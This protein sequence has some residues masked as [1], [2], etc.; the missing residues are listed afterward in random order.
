MFSYVESRDP[1][2][3][4][5]EI[6]GGREAAL[7]DVRDTAEFAA[8]HAKGAVSMPLAKLDSA[9]IRARLGEGVGTTQALYVLSATGVR[10]ERAV[11][12]LRNTGLKNTVLVNGGFEAW[13]N[14]QLPTARNDRRPSLEQQ[15]HIMVGILLVVVLTKAWLLHPAFYALLG[16][17][18]IAMIANGIGQHDPLR[19]LIARLPWNRRSHAQVAPSG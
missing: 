11:H 6:E 16:V 2:A 4:Y 12:R 13:S 3:V 19:V 14:A 8:A 10:A 15:I 7:I 17:M 18:G 5:R 9:R 1:R